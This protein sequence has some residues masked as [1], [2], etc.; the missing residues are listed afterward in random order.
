MKF[1]LYSPHHIEPYLSKREGE[2]KLGE[3]V[4][5]VTQ[6]EDIS[7]HPAPYV[8]IGIPED[9]GVR[10]NHGIGGTQTAWSAFLAKFLNIQENVYQT[11]KNVIVLGAFDFTE[12]YNRND[13]EITVLRELVQTID[14]QVTEVLKI[15]FQ[16]GKIPIIIGG[17]HNNSYP[18]IKAASLGLQQKINCVNLDV[19]ADYRTKEGRHSGNGFRY[20][21][22]EGFLDKY[23]II[24]LHENYNS[25]A[26]LDALNI[27]LAIDFTLFEAIAIREEISLHEAFEKACQFTKGNKVGLELDLDCIEGVLSSAMTPTGFSV[28]EARKFITY[29]KK[30]ASVA[31]LHLCEGVTELETGET[32]K[33]TGKLLSYLVSDFIKNER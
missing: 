21:K 24:G 14:E 20:A 27:D 31:Y 26:L 30:Q 17:G 10:S 4:Q 8:I 29:F 15:V 19:H 22:E 33:Q 2:T 16:A 5:F 25:Q 12:E 32:S 7:N 1:Q 23:Y 6:L 18:N 11:G 9:F 28:T 13:Q 3:C